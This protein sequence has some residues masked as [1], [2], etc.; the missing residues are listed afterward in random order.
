MI[1]RL[2]STL[3]LWTIVIVSLYVFGAQAG[4]WLIALLTLFTQWEF[5]GL[6]EKMGHRV[7][8][9]YGVLWSPILV[10]GSYYLPLYFHV[11]QAGTD[12]VVLAIVATLLLI[13]RKNQITD[14]IPVALTTLFG[15]LYV[16]FLLSF[17]V[18]IL[19]LDG[20]NTATG[21][22]LAIWIV[23]TTKFSD[24]GAL[25]TG[26]ACGRHKLAS[27]LSPK[28]TWEGV[29]GGV[30]LS[31]A[32]GAALP[33]LFPS[34]FPA[35]FNPWIAA[36]LALPIAIVAV[37]SDLIESVIKRVAGVKD[38]GRAIPGIG[39]AFDLTDSMILSAPIGFLLMKYLV[40]S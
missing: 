31:M 7:H 18:Q 33:L 8:K 4:V 24:V 1:S 22:M 37:A 14:Q 34:H 19:F 23:A 27:N 35:A 11:H 3:G 20:G 12:L 15:I 5:Y 36:L 9:K 25:L 30:L 40:F 17:F 21:L 10:L 6:L 38:S 2:F 28:K 26:M 29:A 32:V 16:P 13:V 39:G